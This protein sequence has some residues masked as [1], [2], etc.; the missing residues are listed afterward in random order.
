MAIKLPWKGL[1]L[2]HFVRW[3]MDG[4]GGSAFFTVTA[5]MP[6][7][8]KFIRI[9]TCIPNYFNCYKASA[10]QNSL[11]LGAESSGHDVTPSHLSERHL[12]YGSVRRT[13][14]PE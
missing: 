5:F 11:L 9:K 8:Y 3:Q 12:R 14:P 6:R 7:K 1:Y 13:V 4:K 2:S 10:I